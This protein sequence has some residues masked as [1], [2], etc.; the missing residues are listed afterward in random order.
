MSSV[1]FTIVVPVYKIPYDLLN[2]CL[3]SIVNQTFKNFEVLL[4]DDESPDECGRICNKYA[5]KHN[6]FRAIHQKNGGLSVV[7]NVGFE[8]A[9]GE[10]VCFVDG[11]DWMEKD[12]LKIG[13]Q[14][15]ENVPRDT[16]VLICDAFISTDNEERNNYFLGRK[17]EGTIVFR[18]DDKKR[19]VDLFFPNQKMVHEIGVLCDIGSTWARFYRRKFIVENNL[20]NVPG[21]RRMQ[22]NVFNLYVIDKARAICYN[23]Q[24]IYHYR[25]REDSVSNRYDPHI[26]EAFFKLYS[27]FKK[28]ADLKNN[29]EYRQRAYC[30]M[31]SLSSWIMMNNFANT[32][33]TTSYGIRVK[34]MRTFFEQPLIRDAIEHF[35]P[36][37]QKSSYKLLH[38][39]LLK[40]W[41]YLVLLLSIIHERVKR[42]I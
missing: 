42:I 10:W 24:R 9:E 23:C 18:G 37:N 33:N 7:R 1:K 31:I 26:T 29:D 17:T 30:K 12:A 32:Q 41:Y 28:F 11:D 38:F 20:R 13:A 22:D 6:N 2:V 19:I 39:F 21:L 34:E 14:L 15:L 8:Q 3:D 27:E 5:E 40:K 36:H 35:N 25:L 16:D 4:I